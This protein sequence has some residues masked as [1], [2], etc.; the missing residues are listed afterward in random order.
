MGSSSS[1]TSGPEAEG[2]SA[3]QACRY[4]NKSA[5]AAL[6]SSVKLQRKCCS[7]VLGVY[8]FM[9]ESVASSRTCACLTL[10]PCMPTVLLS[11]SLVCITY[12]SLEQ[13]HHWRCCI[14][15]QQRALMHMSAGN[16]S[17]GKF[18]V[19][20]PHVRQVL[21][22]EEGCRVILGTDGLWDFLATAK[23]FSSTG[24][25]APAAAAQTLCKQAFAAQVC[26]LQSTFQ[27]SSHMS[28]DG[29]YPIMSGWSSLLSVLRISKQ[30]VSYVCDIWCKTGAPA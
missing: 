2:W 8:Q 26:L 19:P 7:A 12:A 13:Q 11:A 27:A 14:F 25:M 10:Q 4:S 6:S 23:I 21:V 29:G 1:L 3:V 30:N 17:I 9:C 22:P 28:D 15:P 18:I 5:S 24:R 20:Y 16:V